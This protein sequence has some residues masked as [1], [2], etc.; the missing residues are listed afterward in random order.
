MRPDLA[1]DVL[2]QQEEQL[3]PRDVMTRVYKL[4]RHRAG[5]VQS[6]LFF[7]FPESPFIRAPFV[8]FLTLLAL[9]RFAPRWLLPGKPQQGTDRGRLISAGP[10]VAISGVLLVMVYALH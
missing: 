4:L 7:S 3:L 5:A 9:G 10:L 6:G 1:G 8:C 2:K